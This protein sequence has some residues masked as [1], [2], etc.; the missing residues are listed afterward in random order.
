MTYMDDISHCFEPE[1]RGLVPPPV[2][3]LTLR[4]AMFV[5]WL[6]QQAYY[7]QPSRFLAEKYAI[8]FPLLI[9]C[10]CKKRIDKA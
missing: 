4:Y 1:Q 9:V 6:A 8:P 10:D 2:W 5:S 7:S 3:Q